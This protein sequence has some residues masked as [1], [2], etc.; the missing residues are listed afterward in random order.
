MVGILLT[1]MNCTFIGMNFLAHAYLSFENP[2]IVVGNIISDYVKGASKNS[3]KKDIR[4]GI[5]LHRRID[6]YTDNHIS[7]K[8]AKEIFRPDYRLYSGA[9]IDVLFDH[10]LAKQIENEEKGSLNRL[11]TTTYSI[12]ED[13]ESD[14]PASFISAKTHMVKHNWLGNYLYFHGIEQSLRGLSMRALYMNNSSRA[15]ELFQIHYNELEKN[16]QNFFPDV[17]QFAK[18]TLVQLLH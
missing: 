3:F 13:Y 18:Q 5:T 6:E 16:F 9:I 12:L 14:L 8:L 11:A 17:K 1:R 15:F 2:Q 4:Q 10:F 7:V